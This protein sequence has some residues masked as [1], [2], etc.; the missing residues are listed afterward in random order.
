MHLRG[1]QRGTSRPAATAMVCHPS[2]LLLVHH[3]LVLLKVRLPAISLSHTRTRD[4][5]PT[6]AAQ[7]RPRSELLLLQDL[8]LTLSIAWEVISSSQR[9][10][11]LLEKMLLLLGRIGHLVLVGEVV[12]RVGGKLVIRQALLVMLKLLLLLEQL[13]LLLLLHILLLLLILKL[14]LLYGSVLLHIV[15]NRLLL[16]QLIGNL[17]LLLCLL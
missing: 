8:L 13:I 7:P 3:H 11:L 9:R 6:H 4:R 14:L 15:C 5:L 1:E 16:L 17:I 12:L 2:S 10:V